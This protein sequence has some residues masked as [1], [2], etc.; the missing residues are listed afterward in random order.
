MRNGYFQI[1]S[2]QGGFGIRVVPPVDGGAPV[3]VSDIIAYLDRQKYYYDPP[4]VKRLVDASVENVM[5]LM[6]GECPKIP[7][8]YLIDISSDYMT[9]TVRFI[10]PSETGKRLTFDE[11]MR[12]LRYRN[13]VSGIQMQVLSEHFQSEGIYLTDLIIAK[14]REPIQGVDDRIEYYFNTETQIAPTLKEDGEVDYYNL[15]IIQR[16]RKG[17]V[18]A[19]VITG[20]PGEHGINVLGKKVAPREV[21]HGVIKYGKNIERIEEGNA[22][23]SMVD[24]HVSLV[25]D[26]V[27]V[28]DV[29]EV[30]NVDFSTGNINYS[31]SVQVNGNVTSGFEVRAEGNVIINGVVEGAYIQAGGDIII[32]RGMN[33]MHKGSLHAGGNIVAK[34]IENSDVEAEGYINTESILHSTVTAGT[35]IEV[36][37]KR[38]FIV[39]GHVQA[40]KQIAVKTLGAAMGASTIV[41]VGIDPKVKANY[42][43]LQRDIGDI[44]KQIKTMQAM[45][46]TFAEKLSKG[47]HFTAEQV[48]YIKGLAKDIED[49]KVELAQ[50]NEELQSLQELIGMQSQAKVIVRGE[51]FPGTTIVIGDISTVIQ[52]NYHYCRFEAVDGNVKMLPI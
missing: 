8:S 33:G 43:L 27:F 30:E 39:G 40:D 3:K 46:T 49:K 13:I 35:E 5:F 19:R 20:N 24:G 31:G 11:F 16:C 52:T 42:M 4:A 47:A 41:E 14:G 1:V 38:G 34:F 9:V 10:P 15:N 32:A 45:L 29:Y 2:V 26:T 44:V 17:D 21:K 22:I 12:D 48:K 50:K 7:E 18:L 23:T 28:S 6:R 51:V 36:E 25:D 37:G